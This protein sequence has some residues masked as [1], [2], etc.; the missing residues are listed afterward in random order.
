MHRG[1]PLSSQ[2]TS[3]YVDGPFY[4]SHKHQPDGPLDWNAD[5]HSKIRILKL[6]TSILNLSS[7]ILKLSSCFLKLR[8]GLNLKTEVLTTGII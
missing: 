6:E 1:L 4:K 7:C 2:G 8:I 3:E 5:F